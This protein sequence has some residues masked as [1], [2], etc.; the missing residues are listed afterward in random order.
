M[1]TNFSYPRGPTASGAPNTPPQKPNRKKSP[2]RLIV[3]TFSAAAG[4]VVLAAVGALGWGLMVYSEALRSP[5]PPLLDDVP[6]SNSVVDA[7][8]NLLAAS[9]AADGIYRIR[10]EL[11][12]LSPELV[13][14]TLYYEDRRFWEHPG[15]DLGAIA[16]AAFLALTG[17]RAAGAS[18]ITMQTVRL[19]DRL[20][21]KTLE[22]KIE[23]IRRAISL[24]AHYSKEDILEAYFNLAPYGGNIEGAEAASMA[25]FRKHAA[26]LTPDEAV[27]L[28]VV[29]QNPVK[30]RPWTGPDFDKARMRLAAALENADRLSPGAAAQL[31]GPLEVQNP[32]RL[33]FLAPHYTRLV[34]SRFPGAR[35]GTLRLSIQKSME[36][37]AADAVKRLS[38]WGIKNAAIAVVDVRTMGLLS[39]VGSADFFNDQIEGEVSAY[40]SLRS[41]GSLLKPFIYAL[42]LD[43]GLIHSRSILLDSPK[44]F[45]GYAPENADGR[46]RG[47]IDASTALIESRNLP[48][49]SLAREINPDLYAFLKT[50]GVPLA[51]DRAHYGLSI[52]LGTAEMS[53]ENLLK[54]YAMLANDGLLKDIRIVQAQQTSPAK[55]MISPE[56]AF[57]VRAMLAE[58]GE[59][60]RVGGKRMPLVYKTG[61]SN[62]FR[63]AWT[64]GRAGPYVAAVWLGN[65]NARPNAYFQGASLAA[66]IWRQAVEVLAR[67]PDVDWPDRYCDILFADTDEGR[68]VRSGLKVSIVDVCR[69]TGDLANGLCTDLAKAWFIP[70]KS[71]TRD[72]G[73]WREILIDKAT[74]LR[75]CRYVPDK[76]EKRA[77]AVWP[78]AYQASFLAAGIVKRPPPPWLP[79]CRPPAEESGAPVMLSPKPGVTYFTGTASKTTAAVTLSAAADKPDRVIYWF[80]GSRF[81]AAGPAETPIEAQ[82]APGVR[83]I[84]AVDELG[85]SS[86]AAL[87]V[88]RP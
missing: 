50:A 15:V 16:R 88:K 61:T 49:I 41:P 7:D 55:P 28:A 31:G 33:P 65:F 13:E 69:D 29:P 18:T 57:V 2:W 27:G 9:P 75:A 63:D 68:A 4:I 25:Y 34:E 51:G 5:A 79:G 21:T 54:L 44:P 39:L 35:I 64:I 26:D 32:Q 76:T 1:T 83:T 30:R 58:R 70:G 47:P 20:N 84:T 85:R 14:A 73:I 56:A 38:P 62:G 8:G 80:D 3:W 19:K 66:P 36:K 46:F 78:P 81:L 74:G 48:A 53:M 52:A 45:G 71:P 87:T 24:E 12:A 23:Q 72:S 11:D 10:T 42:A 43:Q 59:F 60:I 86:T 77:W 67:S 37:L 17:E 82:F 22:G 40:T 6:F